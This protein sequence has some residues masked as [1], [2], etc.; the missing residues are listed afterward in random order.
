M[1]RRVQPVSRSQVADVLYRSA[2]DRADFHDSVCAL[3]EFQISSYHRARRN[4]DGAGR[5]PGGAETHAYSLQ[6]VLGPRS[7]GVA[8]GF[9]G[10]S[11]HSRLLHQQV[12]PGGNGDSRGHAGSLAAPAPSYYDDG[13]CSLSRIAACRALYRHWIGHAKAVRHRD[14]GWA[15]LAALH[16]LLCESRAVR[17]GGARG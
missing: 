8:G 13:P 9:G 5:S 4:Y 14:R 15:D 1:G 11:C 2:G 7:Y 16:W 10:D 17:N 6:R 12:A 3:W